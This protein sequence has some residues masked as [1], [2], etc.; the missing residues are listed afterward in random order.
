MSEL[1]QTQKEAW[2]KG[3]GKNKPKSSCLKCGATKQITRHHVI[4]KAHLSHFKMKKPGAP[5]ASLCRECHC[6]I[7]R[8]ILFTE[9][10]VNRTKVGE[11]KPLPKT[12]DYWDIL[13]LF[14]GLGR[15]SEL[16]RI[17]KVVLH[18]TVP[19]HIHKH[20]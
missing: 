14:I 13:A 8:H 3:F 19:P 9:A 4:P 11:R 2:R 16:M 15:L 18:P 12:D 17:G 20:T 5:T 1:F 7:E 10:F 6:D